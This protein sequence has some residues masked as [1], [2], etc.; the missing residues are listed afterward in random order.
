[1]KYSGSRSGITGPWNSITALL[2]RAEELL[3]DDPE[4][5]LLEFIKSSGIIRVHNYKISGDRP[6][7]TIDCGSVRLAD[8]PRAL[9]RAMFLFE[10]EGLSFK[11]MY[12]GELLCLVSPDY[13]LV[14]TLEFFK[15]ELAVYFSASQDQI[16]GKGSRVVSGLPGSDNGIRFKGAITKSW[17]QLVQTLLDREWDVYGGNH[18]TV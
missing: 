16:E 7:G 14:A 8:T 4:D 13:N 9:Y 2:A 18:F 17:F 5:D 1:M 6:I 10:P 12:K 15:F 3:R 11:S